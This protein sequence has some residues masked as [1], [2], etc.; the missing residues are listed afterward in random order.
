MKC[1]I[2]IIIIIIIIIIVVVI[3]IVIVIIIVVVVN[4]VLSIWK[5]ELFGPALI[6]GIFSSQQ[7]PARL[8]CPPSF[9]FNGY[10]EEYTLE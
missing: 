4:F 3:V 2:Q 8:W 5:K 1:H 9:L 7:R 10:Q 6:P